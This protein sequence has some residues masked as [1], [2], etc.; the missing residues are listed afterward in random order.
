LPARAGVSLKPRHYDEVLEGGGD[1]VGFFEVHAENYMGAGGPPHT[2]LGRI[3]RDFPLSVH[4]VGLSIGGAGPLDTDHLDRL[5]RLCGI[6]QPDAFSEHLAWSSHGSYFYND[7]LPLPYDDETL[8]L[9][10]DHV[11]QVQTRLSRRVLLEN[12]AT[13]LAFDASHIAETDFLAEIARRT[14]CGL[15]LDV[16]NVFVSATNRGFDAASYID[17]FPVAHVAEIHLAGFS[18]D[19]SSGPELLIDS[20]GAPVDPR[21]W[22]LFGRALARTGPVP[23]L[24]EWDNDVPDFAMLCAE[25]EKAERH[26]AAVRMKEAVV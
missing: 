21:V 25:A 14:G 7:L 12:T 24:V 10:A 9:V 3:R 11:D 1:V 19:R 23:V 26:L 6:Y 8:A 13:Y 18:R 4:G 17:A 22:E 20:H 2:Y 5:A 16:A 15:L